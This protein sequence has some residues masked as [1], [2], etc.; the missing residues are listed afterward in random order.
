MLEEE[1]LVLSVR[2]REVE[3]RTYGNRIEVVVK[4]AKAPTIM[5]IK[6]AIITQCG[7]D[8]GT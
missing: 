3:T 1:D 2:K 5:E 4:N 6:T 7:L 8:E